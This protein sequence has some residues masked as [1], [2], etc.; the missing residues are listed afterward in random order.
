MRQLRIG[1]IDLVTKGPDKSLYA[2]VMH[3]NLAS[4]MPQIVATW[5]EQDGHDVTFVC[6]TGRE[7]IADELP[8]NV[9]LVFITSFTQ[10]A[11]LSYAISALF[12]AQGAVTVLGGPH[13]RCYPEDSA[14]YFDYVVGFADHGIIRDIVAD[15]QEHRPLGIQISAATQP[16]S[17][18]GVEER[19]KFAAMA[20]DKAPLL[21]IVPMIGS[22]GCPYT[23]SFCIDSE[24]PY[25][26]MD[27]E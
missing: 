26:P 20:L 19:W 23:C 3:A 14:K 10:A 5:C 18:P 12:R 21:K 11:Q 2:W 15:C 22:L 17:L 9:D 4:I 27:F 7:S 1:V 16:Q 25:Q 13:A 6:Y 8:T 24:V